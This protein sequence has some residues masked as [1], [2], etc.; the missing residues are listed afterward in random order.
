MPVL[1]NYLCHIIKKLSTILRFYE[2]VKVK[3]MHIKSFM[4]RELLRYAT[5]GYI[6]NFR[7]DAWAIYSEQ[8]GDRHL[9]LQD[10]KLRESCNKGQSSTLL[11]L[12]QRI[13][14]ETELRWV[15]MKHFGIIRWWE[16]RRCCHIL[17]SA[18]QDNLCINR[19]WE[20][21]N[22]FDARCKNDGT[23]QPSTSAPRHL[24]VVSV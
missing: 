10:V 20:W 15:M 5:I 13:T 9:V 3:A 11:I 16:P 2:P 18:S 22:F 6:I 19:D 24:C 8:R 12:R 21:N 7:S 17:L 1:I 23:L 14:L 4:H